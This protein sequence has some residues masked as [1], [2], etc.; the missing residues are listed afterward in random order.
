MEL[1]PL[2]E[3]R[4]APSMLL[5]RVASNGCTHEQDFRLDLIEGR[6]GAQQRVRIIRLKRDPC[7]K[8]ELAGKLLK[9]EK[10]RLGLGSHAPFTIENPSHC[11]PTSGTSE[12]GNSA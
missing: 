6:E 10:K 1:E 12:A 11:H 2:W 7:K 9:F 4:N 3:L 8:R 5:I